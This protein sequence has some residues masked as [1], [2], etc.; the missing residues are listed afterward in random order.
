M[1]ILGIIAIAFGAAAYIWKDPRHIMRLSAAASTTWVLYFITHQQWAPMLVTLSFIVVL[2][3]GAQASERTV[4]N[5]VIA[6]EITIIPL[7]LSTASG[8]PALIILSGSLIKGVSPM[9][10]NHPYL[11]RISVATGESLWLTYG[12]VENIP[13]TAAWSIIVITV[14]LT[15]GLYFAWQERR[16]KLALAAVPEVAPT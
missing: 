4:R 14:S 10:R 16:Q 5:L 12:I 6:R 3:A 2:I 15:S 11:F 7:V 1:E 9:L 8:W 13:S